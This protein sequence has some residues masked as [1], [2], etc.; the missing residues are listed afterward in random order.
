MRHGISTPLIKQYFNWIENTVSIPVNYLFESTRLEYSI[1]NL[2]Y[3]HGTYSSCDTWWLSY[4][5]YVISIHM[6]L[7]ISGPMDTV[8]GFLRFFPDDIRFR[9]FCVKKGRFKDD[10]GASSSSS[11]LTRGSSRPFDNEGFLVG[12]E[13]GVFRSL[14][15]V[16]GGEDWRFLFITRIKSS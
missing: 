16:V 13:D 8:V 9:R 6:G 10:S 5:Q 12:A 2:W 7:S 1:S 4:F 14:V 11:C 15:V 3:S